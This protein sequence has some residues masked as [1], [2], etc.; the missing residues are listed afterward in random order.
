MQAG[1]EQ[2]DQLRDKLREADKEVCVSYIRPLVADRS[3]PKAVHLIILQKYTATY[4]ILV[5]A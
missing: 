3:E 1:G 4:S 2:A 5:A